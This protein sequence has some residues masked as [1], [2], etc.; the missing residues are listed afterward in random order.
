MYSYSKTAVLIW[1]LFIH[2]FCTNKFNLQVSDGRLVF[3]LPLR[4]VSAGGLQLRQSVLELKAALC[5]R[6]LQLLTE[7]LRLLL[8]LVLQLK[9]N[10]E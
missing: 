7:L 2:L 6:A 5:V 8:K 9:T 3:V 10:K 1:D 4:Q